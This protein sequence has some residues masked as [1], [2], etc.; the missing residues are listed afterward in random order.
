MD[1]LIITINN[2][3]YKAKFDKQ[4]ETS[5]L[6]NDKLYRIELLKQ[7]GKNIFSFVINNKIVQVELDLKDEGPSTI[8]TDGFSF[9]IEITDETKKLLK[10][11]LANADGADSRRYAIIKAPMPGMIIKILVNE[12]DA[13][14][15]GDKILIIEAMKMEN[16]ISSPISGIVS[17]I[18]VS[19]AKAVEKDAVLMEIINES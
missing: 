9:E 3:E 4:N 1:D 11:F 7:L 15:K 6:L 12:G 19:E 10:K 8:N 13:V 14:V 2:N 16:S 17:S 18:K 5:I